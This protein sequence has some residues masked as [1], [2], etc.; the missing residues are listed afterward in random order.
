MSQAQDN[1]PLEGRAADHRYTPG[2]ECDRCRLQAIGKA[3]GRLPVGGP[4]WS[5]RRPDGTEAPCIDRGSDGVEMYAYDDAYKRRCPKCPNTLLVVFL[6]LSPNA[7]KP[8][9]PARAWVL[10]CRACRH[11]WTEQD[12]GRRL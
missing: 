9:D 6:E 2:C 1:S 5:V 12:N 11:Q 3:H 8:D 7:G 4:R 10:H